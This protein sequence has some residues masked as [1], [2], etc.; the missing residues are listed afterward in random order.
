MACPRSMCCEGKSNPLAFTLES[1]FSRSMVDSTQRGCSCAPHKA[2]D[3]E[4]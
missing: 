3:L 1:R 2:M 4:I